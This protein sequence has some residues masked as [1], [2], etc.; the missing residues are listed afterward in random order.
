MR[1]RTSLTATTLLVGA[2]AVLAIGSYATA[3]SGKKNVAADTMIGY[4]EAPPVSTVARGSFEAEIDDEAQEIHYTLSYSGLEDV[5]RQAHIHFGQRGVSAGISA[6]LCQTTL[7]PAPAGTAP[8]TCPQAG[9]VTGTIRPTDVT[10]MAAAQGIAAGEFGELV[11]ALRAG[12]AYANVH[13]TKFPPGEIRGQ[14]NDD[15]Q[16]DD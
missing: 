8:P 3:D 15:N 1:K 12:R 11:A 2:L 5:V 4:Q 9:T 7:N 10:S 16:K 13:T 6:W 14:I